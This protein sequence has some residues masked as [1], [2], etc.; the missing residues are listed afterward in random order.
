ESLT[1]SELVRD[2][3]LWTMSPDLP[4]SEG[5]AEM[6]V[7]GFDVAPLTEIPIARFVRR[8]DLD[9]NDSSLSLKELAHPLTADICI[10][11]AEPL[12]EVLEA[13]RERPF[14]FV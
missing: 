14:V 4:V 8:G 6:S 2:Q 1:V 5:H 10:D 12:S 11:E 7:R 13:L 3:Q 9:R